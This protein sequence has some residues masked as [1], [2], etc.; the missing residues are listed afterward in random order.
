MG[1]FLKQFFDIKFWKFLMVGVINTIVG[2]GLQFLLYN[3]FGWEKFL[4][5]VIAATLLG[6]LV[7]GTVSY[8]LNKHFTFKNK[9]KGWKPVFRF[10]VNIAACYVIAYV[11]ISPIVSWI[12]TANPIFFCQACGEHIDAAAKTCSSC[13]AQITEYATY[14]GWSLEKFAGNVSMTIGACAFVA[15]NYI[16]QRFFAFKE[17]E[18]IKTTKEDSQ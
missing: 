17:K 6:N 18:N 15:C 16:G 12:C 3:L 2:M 11:V 9:E 14:F 13:G 10:A 8:L 4:W 1:N 7:G 5:G